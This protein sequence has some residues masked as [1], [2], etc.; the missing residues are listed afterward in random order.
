M[1]ATARAAVYTGRATN[2]PALIIG[3]ALLVLLIGMG[4]TGEASSGSPGA[5]APLAVV[6]VVSAGIAVMTTS[7]RASA[8]PRG[9]TAHFGVFGWPRFR[10]PLARIAHAEAVDVPAWPWAW[11]WG[12]FWSPSWGTM[13]T[14]RGGGALRLT[15]VG[16]RT[17]TISTPDPEAAVAA[18]EDARR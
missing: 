4:M 2:W 12:P 18:L 13:L 9:V 7:L 5:V 17:V 1:S 16:G 15:L 3:A 14:L 10:Y 11:I 8:G 6:L